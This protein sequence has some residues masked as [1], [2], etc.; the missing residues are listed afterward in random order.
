MSEI[1]K[2]RFKKV[3]QLRKHS[4]IPRQAIDNHEKEMA[5][6]R[7]FIVEDRIEVVGDLIAVLHAAPPQKTFFRD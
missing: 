7:E 4:P 1:W 2:T 5:F 6:W 3:G